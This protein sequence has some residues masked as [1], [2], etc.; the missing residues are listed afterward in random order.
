MTKTLK[1]LEAE[2]SAYTQ[3]TQ[4]KIDQMIYK[5][6]HFITSPL[7]WR[8]YVTRA[9]QRVRYGYSDA[10][11][12]NG[13]TFLAANIAGILTWIVEHGNGVATSYQDPEEGW[14]PDVD[15]MVERRD[16]EYIKYAAVFAEYAKNGLAISEDWQKE[17]GG[18]LEK[19]MEDALEWLKQ[20]FYELWDQV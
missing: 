12:W 14:Y 11:A 5:I 18:I 6:R 15:R 19:D 10:D 17:L 16:A 7:R 9:Y 2:H 13:D 20:H 3:T 1:E 4:Y 8:R